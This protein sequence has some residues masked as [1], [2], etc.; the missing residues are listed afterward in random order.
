VKLD[1]L[2]LMEIASLFFGA[3]MLFSGIFFAGDSLTRIAEFIQGGESWVLVSKLLA[4]TFPM[5]L[6]MTAPMG[7][8]LATLLGIGRLSN[9]SE[10]IGLSAAGVSFPRMMVPVALFSLCVALP[11]VFLNQTL[12]PM[13]NKGRQEIIEGVRKKG[14]AGMS[15]RNPLSL[16]LP[17]EGGKTMTLHAQGG[18]DYGATLSGKATMYDVAVIYRENGLVKEVVSGDR[19]DTV[20]GTKNWNLTGRVCVMSRAPENSQFQATTFAEGMRTI[21]NVV[22]E[23]AGT[24]YALSVLSGLEA[25]RTNS[26]LRERARTHRAAGNEKD[27]LAAEVEIA[28]RVAMP[29]ATVI[30]ALVGA[31]LGV[32][33]RREGKGMGFAYAV[34]ITFAY[35][36]SQ[37]LVMALAKGGALP[38]MLAM[39]LPNIVGLVVGIFLIR[40]VLR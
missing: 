4:Y 22:I 17:M 15:T 28:R 18:V 3:T 9:D 39:N 26:E 11:W 31:P 29:L 35:W 14:G 24:P 5:I 19:A 30:F 37:N 23:N 6:S 25:E 32:A 12:V 27:A 21:E 20:L 1:R 40:R 38:P 34:A 10:I 8:L 13:A 36:M 16:T 2:I 7:M 33:Q